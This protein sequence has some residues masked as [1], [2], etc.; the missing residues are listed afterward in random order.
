VRID[1]QHIPES[2]VD[3][4]ARLRSA[5]YEAYIVGGAV[6]DLLLQRQCLDFDVTTSATPDQVCSVFD[7]TAPTGLKHGTVTVI[8]P[9]GNVEVTTMRK[10]G[11]YVDGRRPSSVC[12]VSEIEV[13]LARRDF[14][15]NAIAYDPI[16][17]RLFDPYGGCEDLV[18]RVIRAVGN[19]GDRFAEDR[20]RMLRAV[21]IATALGFTIEP[22]T[23]DAI[24]RMSSL[25]TTISAERIRDE[26]LKLMSCDKPSKGIELMRVTGLL[27]GI[28]PELL[29]GYG[30]VQ[31]RYHAYTVYEHNLRTADALRNDPYLRMAGLLHDTG[32]PAV[33]SGEHFYGHERESARIARRVLVRLRFPRRVADRIVH[34]I[35]Q[36][37]FWYESR[38]SDAA[39]RRFI[40]RVGVEHLNDLFE[41]RRADRM[42]SGRD[43]DPSL[44]ELIERVR[45]MLSNGVALTVHDLAIGGD[46]VRKLLSP[47]MSAAIVGRVLEQLLEDVMEDPA[48]NN[49]EALTSRARELVNKCV[50]FRKQL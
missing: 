14:T 27:V 23:L 11:I 49:R 36:H 41:L 24:S 30:V 6:R 20:L 46:E 13:D 44:D 19:P 28:I 16:D 35:A 8:L 9:F 47:G 7:H 5:G 1:R 40:K 3:V 26:L 29:D 15:V 25:I 21:R 43:V 17:D 12:F 42:G 31:N 2:V 45:S 37:M 10:E 22:A 33:K 4:C 38:W 32:K 18:N 48:L 50:D 39:V 34:L